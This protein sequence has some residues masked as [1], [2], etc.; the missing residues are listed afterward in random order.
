MYKILI[1]DDEEKHVTATME[2][3]TSSGFNT[4]GTTCAKKAFVLV[5]KMQPDLIILDVLM[6]EIDGYQFINR[7]KMNLPFVQIPFLFLTAKGMT[8]DRIK[9]YSLGCSGYV[10]KP[11]DPE[12]LVAIIENILLRKRQKL[13]D[14]MIL[15]KEVALIRDTLESHYSVSKK[16]IASLDLTSREI[17]VLNYVFQG[18]KNRDIASQLSTSVRNIEKYLTK[19]FSKTNTNSRIGLLNYCYT[20]K[21]I[22][23]ANDGIR[24]RE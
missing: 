7:L 2:Y 16:L 22:I 17:A 23:R 13:L 24:T 14:L 6:P 15:L 8:Q 12:E 20:N 5:Q 11:F 3:L 21:N 18:L 1:L 4:F 19:L 9:G 10:P